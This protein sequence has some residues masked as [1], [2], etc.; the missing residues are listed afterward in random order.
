MISLKNISRV[1]AS[2]SS[3]DVVALDNINLTLPEKGFVTIVGASG[4]G[5]T[6]LLNVL[7]GLDSPTSGHMIVDGISTESFKDKDWDAYRNEKIGFVL[8]NCFLLP[9][10]SIRDNVLIKLQI[11]NRKYA[12]ELSNCREPG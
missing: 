2:K 4:S 8:Q 7:G 5:K 12:R 11:S 3:E 9:H 6:T 1:Y 10:L